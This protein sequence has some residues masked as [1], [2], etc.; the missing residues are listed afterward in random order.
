MATYDRFHRQCRTLENLFD[1][2]LTT[3]AQLAVTIAQPSQD[4]E[5][6][7]SSG[8]W[9]DLELELEDLLSKV[10]NTLQLIS[11]SLSNSHC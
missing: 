6:T 11:N 4:V 1:S 2:K 9:K 10:W 7:G 5:A 3:Y 8:R